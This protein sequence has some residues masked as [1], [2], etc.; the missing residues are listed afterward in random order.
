ME[1]EE[2]IKN[3]E[4]NR[5]NDS[6]RNNFLIGFIGTNRTGKSSLAKKVA[7]MWRLKYPSQTVMSFDPQDNFGEITDIFIDIEDSE[8]PYKA[9]KLRDAL[10]ILDDYKLIND[11]D[12][13]IK[14]LSKLMAYRAKYNIDIIY[15]CHNPALVLNLLTY[16]TTHYYIFL[17]QAQ[18]DGF[19]K[20]I[21]NYT[22][23]NNASRMVNEWVS[24]FGR[25]EYPVFPYAIIDT[26]RQVIIPQ[27]IDKRWVNIYLQS[28]DLEDKSDLDFYEKKLKNEIEF[29]N[30]INKKK[31]LLK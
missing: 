26:E 27:N 25:G 12:R 11:I 7:E 17:T 9:L 22:L 2:I 16:Y 24:K 8:W 30:S 15:V 5:L 28:M 6:Y 4:I 19:K 21:P 10:L 13:P 14:G 31:G 20:K 3:E 1:R 18:E 23:C 29:Q